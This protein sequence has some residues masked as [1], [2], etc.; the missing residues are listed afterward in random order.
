MLNRGKKLEMC[1]SNFFHK[2]LET[3]YRIINQQSQTCNIFAC[4][5]KLEQT[6]LNEQIE[7]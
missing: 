4:N 7:Q 5:V 6:C 1:S 2:E 3:D